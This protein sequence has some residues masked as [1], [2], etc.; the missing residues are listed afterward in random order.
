MPHPLHG[1]SINSAPASCHTSARATSVAGRA[2]VW[3]EAG[4]L[5]MLRPW[6]GWGIGSYQVLTRVEPQKIHADSALLTLAAEGGVVTVLAF[7][8]MVLE[9]ARLARKAPT[10]VWWAL[11]AFG[12]HQLVDFTLFSPLVALPLAATLGLLEAEWT[13]EPL[14]TV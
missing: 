4:A 10:R 14:Q 2:D 13:P 6:S 9:V 5:F 1:R 3:Q 11:L 12:L 8:V 7:G